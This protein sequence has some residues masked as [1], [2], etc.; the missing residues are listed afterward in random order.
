M[1][2][3]RLIYSRRAHC[4]LIDPTVGGAKVPVGGAL[5]IFLMVGGHGAPDLNQEVGVLY[6]GHLVPLELLLRRLLLQLT[7]SRDCE[8][9]DRLG[10]GLVDEQELLL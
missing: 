8:G 7:F 4:A 1:M 5:L 6:C 9:L 3:T 10:L 2:A